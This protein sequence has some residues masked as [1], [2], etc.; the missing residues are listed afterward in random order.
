MPVIYLPILSNIAPVTGTKAT[1]VS[2]GSE[3][4]LNYLS[5][6]IWYLT[7]TKHDNAWN[8]WTI[9]AYAV[10]W[11]DWQNFKYWTISVLKNYKKCRYVYTFAPTI[12]QAKGSQYWITVINH[13]TY[14][15]VTVELVTSKM[16]NVLTSAFLPPT[17]GV[18]CC[19]EWVGRLHRIRTTCVSSYPS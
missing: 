14:S 12:Q 15:V 11:Y 8:M 2:E 13:H 6:I 9:S 7:T 18:G 4:N 5:I 1:S 17:H 3:G 19:G 16:L 10:I